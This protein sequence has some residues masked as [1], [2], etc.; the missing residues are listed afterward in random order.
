MRWDE[1]WAHSDQPIR[2]KQ[3]ISSPPLLLQKIINNAGLQVSDASCL[4]FPIAAT[5]N[6][7]FPFLSLLSMPLRPL[8]YFTASYSV[9]IGFCDRIPTS[10][11]SLS[12][13]LPVAH[14][15]C[16]SFNYNPVTRLPLEICFSAFHSLTAKTRTIQWLGW[17]ILQPWSDRDEKIKIKQ[18]ERK[19]YCLLR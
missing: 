11:C 5:P 3:E 15:F 2:H 18:E 19:I 17:E 7:C 13:Q 10:I 6:F 16:V 12:L 1:L 4:L 9:H 8:T 14:M